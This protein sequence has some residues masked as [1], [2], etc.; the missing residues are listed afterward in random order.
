MLQQRQ[1]VGTPSSSSSFI[2]GS[3]S[4]L[5]PPAPNIFTN[6][7]IIFPPQH[8][9]HEYP[10]PSLFHDIFRSS[11][12]VFAVLKPFKEE[13]RSKGRRHLIRVVLVD[14]FCS[15]SALP[16]YWCELCQ[17]NMETRQRRGLLKYL[18]NDKSCQKGLNG[19]FCPRTHIQLE[20]TKLNKIWA[21]DERFFRSQSRAYKSC[22]SN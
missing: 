9:F 13:L 12:V 18:G 4:V 6:I 21:D 20:R 2:W 22:S 7:P 17:P 11:A 5:R 1:V 10:G 16:P 8:D 15:I 19:M 14:A 3:D